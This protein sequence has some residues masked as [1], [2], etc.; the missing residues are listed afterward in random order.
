MYESLIIYYSFIFITYSSFIC[1][2]HHKKHIIARQCYHDDVMYLYDYKGRLGEGV[3][4]CHL[5]K[6]CFYANVYLVPTTG[7]IRQP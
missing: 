4:E 2:L 5:S 1:N 3:E 7:D 6:N